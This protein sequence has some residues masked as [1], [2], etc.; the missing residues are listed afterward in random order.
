M[1]Q[2]VG[3]VR[4]VQPGKPRRCFNAEASSGYL[5][6]FRTGQRSTIIREADE[7]TIEGGIPERR[8]Q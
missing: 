6:E 7:P 5:A 2:Q 1:Q 3:V 4:F 8:E